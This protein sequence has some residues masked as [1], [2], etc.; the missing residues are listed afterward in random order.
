MIIKLKEVYKRNS[1]AS[2]PL[3]RV[4]YKIRE[5]F[6]NPEHIVCIRPNTEMRSRL[7]EGLITEAPPTTNFC[8]ISLNRGQ[9]GTDIVVVGTLDE[10]NTKIEER[11][12]LHG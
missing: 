5:I 2:N 6:I 3:D 8:T 1:T 12:V 7:S 11:Q 4:K 10:L 9:S